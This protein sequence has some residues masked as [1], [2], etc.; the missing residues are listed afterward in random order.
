MN[1]GNTGSNYDAI[2][3]LNYNRANSLFYNKWL[4]SFCKDYLGERTIEVGSGVGTFTEMASKISKHVLAVEVAGNCAAELKK[5]FLNDSR[6]KILHRSIIDVNSKKYKG[7]DSAISFNVFE[8]IKNDMS[9]LINVR[10]ILKIGGKFSLFVPCGRKI[11]GPQ[12]LKIGHFRRYE[13]KELTDKLKKA[14]FKILEARYVNSAGYLAWWFL[15][16]TRSTITNG[17]VLLFD[18]IIA[19]WLRFA[20]KVIN[21]PFGLSLFIL[22]EKVNKKRQQ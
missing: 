22:A 20:E 4:F 16:K 18:R 21:P 7:Y 11:F 5:R 9:A 8:H 2:E 6:V 19:S 17:N 1:K 3:E 10:K 12:D 15:K 13:K 14:G